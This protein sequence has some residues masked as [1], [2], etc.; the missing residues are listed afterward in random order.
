MNSAQGA[1]TLAPLRRGFFSAA[2]RVMIAEGEVRRSEVLVVARVTPASVLVPVLLF[3][4]MLGSAV[5]QTSGGPTTV[6]SWFDRHNTEIFTLVGV[7]IGAVAAA[8]LAW[9]RERH[10]D[11][12][13]RRALAGALYQELLQLAIQCYGGCDQMEQFLQRPG[14][15]QTAGMQISI[16]RS[17]KLPRPTIFEES[18]SHLG[19]LSDSVVQRLVAFYIILA[20]SR[21]DVDRWNSEPAASATSSRDAKIFAQ[22]WFQLCRLAADALKELCR[23]LGLPKANIPTQPD[24]DLVALLRERAGSPQ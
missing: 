5:A 11:T 16:L 24:V 23:Y 6:P 7:I 9:L 13:A 3:L 15:P 21:D 20:F 12:I 18:S 22:R 1:P 19:M 2:I 10:R 4:A 17:F 14:E 8:L